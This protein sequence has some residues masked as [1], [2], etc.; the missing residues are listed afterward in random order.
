MTTNRRPATEADMTVGSIVHKGNGAQAWRIVWVG[1]PGG[2]ES[3]GTRYVVVKAESARKTPGNNAAL[4]LR[5]FT[6]EG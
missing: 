5:D 4:P 6:V 1:F 2:I 3:I